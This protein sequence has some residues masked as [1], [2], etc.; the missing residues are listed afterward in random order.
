M[1]LKQCPFCKSR[2]VDIAYQH[3]KAIDCTTTKPTRFGFIVGCMNPHCE[4]QPVLKYYY[5]TEEAMEAWN[6]RIKK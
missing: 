4:A 1:R 2:K 5:T 6:D 3:P